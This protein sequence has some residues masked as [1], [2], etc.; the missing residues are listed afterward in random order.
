MQAFTFMLC[1]PLVCKLRLVATVEFFAR[2]PL[3]G[4]SHNLPTP[5]TN[6]HTHTH[7]QCSNVQQCK[8]EKADSQQS[9]N[10]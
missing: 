4:V 10:L 8:Q 6:M 5:H 2:C 7:T 9:M 1:V 3:H